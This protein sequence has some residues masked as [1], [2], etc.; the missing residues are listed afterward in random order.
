MELARAAQVGVPLAVEVE[1]A[2]AEVEA[3]EVEADQSFIHS[4]F[5]CACEIVRLR[6]AGGSL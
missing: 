1:A 2:E 6:S 3:A 4:W 5:F